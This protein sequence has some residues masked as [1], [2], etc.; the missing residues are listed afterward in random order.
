M[1]KR[2]L[3]DQIVSIF[4]QGKERNYRPN[5]EKVV[6]KGLSFKIYWTHWDALVVR[7]GVLYK[8]WVAPNL[9]SSI[10]QVIV[11]QKHGYWRRLMILRLAATLE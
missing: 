5:W 6:A 7:N 2:E 9:K 10:L 3:E 4:L 8:K 1:T 11:L